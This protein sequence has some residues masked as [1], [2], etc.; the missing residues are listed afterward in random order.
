MEEWVLLLVN[1]Q[2]LAYSFTKSNTPPLVF[3]MFF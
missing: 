2:I 3:F 1:L